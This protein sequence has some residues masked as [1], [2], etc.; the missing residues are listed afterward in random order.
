M[1]RWA[2]QGYESDIHEGQAGS[3]S[4][5]ASWTFTQLPAGLYQ[6][7]A[8]WSPYSNRASNSPF[9][10]WDGSQLLGISASTNRLQRMIL[11]MRV[12]IGSLLVRSIR[13][14][15]VH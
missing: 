10:V 6:V 14:T 2:G 5:V 15:A 13:S 9:S 3:G 11:L 8:T 1:A 4:D 7:A 12:Q